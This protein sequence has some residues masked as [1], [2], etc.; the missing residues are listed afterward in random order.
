[1]TDLRQR[2]P[3]PE[4]MD[5]DAV[6]PEEF[7]ACI[8]DL[9]KV[10]TVTL[11]RPP[12]LTFLDRAFAAT[13]SQRVLT[14]VDVGFGAGDMLRSLARRARRRGRVVRLVG[15][16]INP[17]SE[18]VARR[19]TAPDMAIDYRTGDAFAMAQNEPVDLVVSSLVTHHMSDAGI[20][21]FL[22]WMERKA[23]LGWFVNDLHRSAIAY[24]GFTL[25]SAAMRWHPFVRHD[26]PLSIARA[27]RRDDWDGLLARAGLG[28]RAN[29]HWRFP[30]RYC[31]ER[32]KW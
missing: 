27:F 31:V 17:R 3:E 24:H 23:E 25:L 14:V 21:D 12:T 9:A 20:V 28:G 22:R 8:E 10:N 15:F 11:A 18:P 6:T 7:A 26:G 19:L 1:M 30:F 13:P 5:G 4:W 32:T 16:D 2:S 29:V